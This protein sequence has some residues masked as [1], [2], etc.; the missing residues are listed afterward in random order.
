MKKAIVASLVAVL[1]IVVA[2]A[3]H[4]G[5][6]GCHLRQHKHVVVCRNDTNDTYR[7]RLRVRLDNGTRHRFGFTL[8]PADRWRKRFAR[9]V[10]GMS[11]HREL[12]VTGPP[13]VPGTQ[14]F[15]DGRLAVY[16]NTYFNGANDQTDLYFVNETAS[17]ISY[18][19]T[20]TTYI[21]GGSGPGNYSDPDLPA[22]QYDS[23]SEGGATSVSGMSCTSS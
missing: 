20:W 23:L 3:A 12:I 14:Q 16:A 6:A 22:Y 10:V 21:T 18:A 5:S 17:P 2:P 13:T 4:A 9:R 1:M 8:D 11:L 19:C 7:M 15:N